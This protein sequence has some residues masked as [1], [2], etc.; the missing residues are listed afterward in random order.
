MDQL[1]TVDLDLIL[2][3]SFSVEDIESVFNGSVIEF[4]Q[5][6]IF[7]YSGWADITV[8]SALYTPPDCTIPVEDISANSPSV[9]SATL[10][11]PDGL[12]ECD[13]TRHMT[14]TFRLNGSLE[15]ERTAALRTKIETIYMSVVKAVGARQAVIQTRPFFQSGACVPVPGDIK[16]DV[17]DFFGFDVDVAMSM[18]SAAPSKTSALSDRLL[19]CWRCMQYKP[20]DA[21]MYDNIDNVFPLFAALGHIVVSG[22]F[23]ACDVCTNMLTVR[24]G[25]VP[26]SKSDYAPA[27]GNYILEVQKIISG[28]SE[29]QF[30]H[31]GYMKG[32]FYTQIGAAHYYSRH[33]CHM[34]PIRS[35]TS[36]ASNCD[37]VTKLRYI[38]R[39]RLNSA[40]SIEP[41][42]AM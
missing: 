17:D 6:S 20:V 7:V 33:N 32:S 37:P 38:V 36:W 35:E 12:D 2:Q 26:L 40:Q 18:Y 30:Y 10:A 14:L 9:I 15:T 5:D 13:G 34:P 25:I 39:E 8:C 19:C 21:F 11:N 42:H 4:K 24:P 23:K 41:F 1:T 29:D 3:R 28:H 16:Q 22:V 31:I 27:T